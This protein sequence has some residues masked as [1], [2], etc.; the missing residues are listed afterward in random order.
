MRKGREFGIF[1]APFQHLIGG[2]DQV[3]RTLHLENRRLQGFA[4]AAHPLLFGD[5]GAHGV[6]PDFLLL[7]LEVGDLVG[8]QQQVGL[9]DRLKKRIG[10]VVA[11]LEPDAGTGKPAGL[12]SAARLEADL[13]VLESLADAITLLEGL[14]HG[15]PQ[16]P[17]QFDG[18]LASLHGDGEFLVLMILQD[19]P[20]IPVQ[21]RDHRRRGVHHR[22]DQFFLIVDLLLQPVHRS[23]IAMHPQI[24]D[25]LVVFIYQGR[26]GQFGQ[27]N[28]AVFTAVHQQ[29][30]PGTAV[31]QAIP[32]LLIDSRRGAL[33]G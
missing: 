30:G 33:M 20:A 6:G 28:G 27:V 18:G 8:H 31:H 24:I 22:F 26:H 23:D 10:A 13:L 5:Q 1:P 21:Q 11:F 12:F 4:H 29:T 7:P 25:S 16:R 19:D 3:E 32:H 14:T 17:Q 9:P 2:G 15:L